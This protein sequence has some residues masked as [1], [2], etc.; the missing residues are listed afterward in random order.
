M[1]F[2]SSINMPL[3]LSGKVIDGLTKV[4]YTIFFY[5]VDIMDLRTVLLDFLSCNVHI[6][7]LRVIVGNM[8]R[9]PQSAVKFHCFLV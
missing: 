9:V 5:L 8:H 6:S 7:G 3:D 4:E 1:D 2:N